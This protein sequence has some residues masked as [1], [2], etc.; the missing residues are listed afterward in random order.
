LYFNQ[1]E[2]AVF[3]LFILQR[4]GAEKDY[5]PEI[6]T[7]AEEL[8]KKMDDHQRFVLRRSIIDNF[9]GFK[10]VTLNDIREMLAKYKT[11]SRKDLENNLKFF[12]SEVCPVAEK[13]GCIMVIHPDDPPYSILGLPRIFSDINDV[14]NLLK[15]V[16]SPANGICFCAGS[17]SGRQDNDIVA[18]FKEC[19]DRV[20][21]VHL[22]STQHDGKGNFFEAIDAPLEAIAGTIHEQQE[23]VDEIKQEVENLY[24]QYDKKTQ[25]KIRQQ[26]H[27]NAVKQKKEIV[28]HL[29]IITNKLFGKNKKT[30]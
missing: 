20:G 18:M 8:F 1:V 11:L 3:E 22:R 30:S 4:K 23:E 2:F 28:E 13:A 9:P 6:I 14:R 21:F 17:F 15:M 27:E 16:D 26:S 10:G 19:A 5:T 7:R 12:L 25:I 29:N 24:E